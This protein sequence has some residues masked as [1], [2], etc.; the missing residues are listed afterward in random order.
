MQNAVGI[1][2]TITANVSRP[3][4]NTAYTAGDAVTSTATNADVTPLVFQVPRDSGRIMGCRAVVTPASGNLVITALDFDLLLFRP[5]TDIPFAAGSYIGD[6]KAMAIS[7]AAYRELV[8]VFRFSSSSW[9]N[10]LGAVTAGITGYQSVALNSSRIMAPYNVQGL[11]HQLNGL[12]QIL[13]AWTPTGVINR[14]DFALDVDL[15]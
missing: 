7:A 2:A 13:G 1:T 9:R 8:A 14:F 4:D 12:I 11:S 15:D 10:T 5:A 3:A 6:N